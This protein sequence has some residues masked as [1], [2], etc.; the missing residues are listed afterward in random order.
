MESQGRHPVAEEDID[1]TVD[2]LAP[3]AV[4]VGL[5]RD[6]ECF[7]IV[8]GNFAMGT[9]DIAASVLVEIDG[10]RMLGDFGESVTFLREGHLAVGL[11]ADGFTAAGVSSV[12]AFAALLAAGA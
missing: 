12:G 5:F 6:V 11:E 2:H 8:L 9:L 4:H 10:E 1:G 7:E 3:L